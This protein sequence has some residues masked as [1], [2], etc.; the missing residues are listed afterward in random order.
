MNS[1]VWLNVSNI[2]EYISLP[3]LI[4]INPPSYI[5]ILGNSFLKLLSRV[6]LFFL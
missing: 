1:G 6:M 3:F 2:S 4:D 5:D